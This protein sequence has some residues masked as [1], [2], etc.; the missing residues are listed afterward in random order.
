MTT[1]TALIFDNGIIKLSIETKW[2]G[3][4]WNDFWLGVI[5]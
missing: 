5:V 2:L 1:Q 4:K 3:K